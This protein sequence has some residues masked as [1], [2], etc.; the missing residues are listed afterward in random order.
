MAVLSVAVACSS[1]PR[2]LSP[3]KDVQTTT[4]AARTPEDSATPATADDGQWLMPARDYASTRYSGLDQITTE[5]VGGG[6]LR[7]HLVHLGCLLL[8]RGTR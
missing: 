7:L 8:S 2:K 6:A 1:A 4:L 3:P 5:N